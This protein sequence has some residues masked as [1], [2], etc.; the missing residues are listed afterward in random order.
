MGELS[1]KDAAFNRLLVHGW[2][3]HTRTPY[4]REVLAAMQAVC[5]NPRHEEHTGPLCPRVVLEWARKQREQAFNFGLSTMTRVE[6]G[7]A[8]LSLQELATLLRG[9]S[10]PDPQPEGGQETQSA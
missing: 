10:E 6:R 5:G 3:Y 8:A 9:E 7:E 4:V 1:D 2:A